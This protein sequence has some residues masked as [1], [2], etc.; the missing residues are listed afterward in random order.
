MYEECR[1]VQIGRYN[2]YQIAHL[3]LYEQEGPPPPSILVGLDSCRLIFRGDSN[4]LS[5][6]K[7]KSTETRISISESGN[8]AD[9]LLGPLQTVH[10]L[11]IRHQDAV[12]NPNLYF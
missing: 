1:W 3:S 12:V 9:G 6:S 5:A 8:I 10:R 7:T 11:S 4:K 2:I